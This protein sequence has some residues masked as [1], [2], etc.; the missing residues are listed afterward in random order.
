MCGYIGFF[1]SYKLIQMFLKEL[2]IWSHLL[3][4]PIHDF[5]LKTKLF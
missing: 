2:K 5:L 3:V 1:A 4:L